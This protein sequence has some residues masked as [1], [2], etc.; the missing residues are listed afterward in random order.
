LLA[1]AD[2][3]AR[4]EAFEKYRVTEAEVR[5]LTSL[6]YE[7]ATWR[8]QHE[9]KV[10]LTWVAERHR[11]IQAEIDT[12]KPPPRRLSSNGSVPIQSHARGPAS[13]ANGKS[14]VFGEQYG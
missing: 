13:R 6:G 14:P 10:M 7:E 12:L 8:N 11:L 5:Q 1:V 4:E 3:S 2:L 9:A